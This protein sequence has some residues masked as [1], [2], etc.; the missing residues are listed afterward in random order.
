MDKDFKKKLFE[1]ALPVTV[2]CLMQSSLSL[3]DQIMIGSLGSQCIA[4]IGL[5]GKFTSLFN[6][7]FFKG[8]LQKCFCYSYAYFDRRVLM[9]PW[10]KCLRCNLRTSMLLL[11][12]D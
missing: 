2:Q 6:S 3:I 9:V 7:S 5:A 11:K 8:I 10:R 1:I 12:H 4:G